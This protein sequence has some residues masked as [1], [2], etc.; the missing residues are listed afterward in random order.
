MIYK[1]FDV[2]NFYEF[3]RK[4]EIEE[5]LDRKFVLL[6]NRTGKR[7]PDEQA[8]HPSPVRSFVW[9][10]FDRGEIADLVAWLDDRRGRAVPFWLPTYQQD[11]TL[12]E[13]L[14]EDDST[15]SI[16]WVRYTQQ[17]FPN[18]N[19]RRHLVLFAP[20]LPLEV[21]GIVDADDPGTFQTETLNLEPAAVRDYPAATTILSFLKL[22]RLEDD[23]VEI[24]WDSRDVAEATIR[25]REIPDET[26]DPEA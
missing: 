6:D 4:G 24:A 14:L 12:A 11:L 1:G 10:C 20:G 26:P 18:T 13:D 7:T 22:C 15:A 17:L 8:P 21:Y 23:E 5:T 9:T 2:L 25:V 19:G 16:L 3:N